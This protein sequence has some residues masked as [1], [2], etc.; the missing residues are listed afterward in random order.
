MSRTKL[1]V[2]ATASATQRAVLTSVLTVKGLGAESATG[3][4]G[5]DPLEAAV[6]TDAPT[7]NVGITEINNNS[8]NTQGRSPLPVES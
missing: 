4:K 3:H 5:K 2:S 7:S 1:Q 6:E 8:A